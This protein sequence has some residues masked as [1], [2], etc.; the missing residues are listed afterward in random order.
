MFQENIADV[1]KDIAKKTDKRNIGESS[2]LNSE[3]S[4]LTSAPPPVPVNQ[5]RSKR[6]KTQRICLRSR[7]LAV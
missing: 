4:D 7:H 6:L 5:I 1:I 3:L 2:D